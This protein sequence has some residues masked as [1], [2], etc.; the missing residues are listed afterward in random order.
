[1]Q[2]LDKLWPFIPLCG[3]SNIVNFVKN[4]KESFTSDDYPE[5]DYISIIIG[6]VFYLVILIPTLIALYKLLPDYFSKGLHMFLG[7]F[8]G[9]FWIVILIMY[10]G[11]SGYKITE[12]SARNRNRRK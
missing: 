11:F 8:L 10:C 12:Q 2:F 7:V 4:K 1:M 3:I 5:F 6:F 9:Q